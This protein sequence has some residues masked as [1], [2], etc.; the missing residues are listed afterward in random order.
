MARVQ[1]QLVQADGSLSHSNTLALPDRVHF[2]GA[3]HSKKNRPQGGNQGSGK[4]PDYQVL[5]VW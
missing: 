2:L 4:I 5:P 1:L 3:K